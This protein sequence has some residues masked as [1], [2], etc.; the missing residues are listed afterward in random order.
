MSD[1]TIDEIKVILCQFIG[2]LDQDGCPV[3][4]FK[5]KGFVGLTLAQLTGRIKHLLSFATQ[6]INDLE[7]SL[8]LLV[9]LWRCNHPIIRFL[10]CLELRPAQAL[11]VIFDSLYVLHKYDNPSRPAAV[12]QSRLARMLKLKTRKALIS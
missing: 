12:M 1:K 11:L 8:S 9:V 2:F 5:R 10:S 3:S 7:Y 6:P 4:F